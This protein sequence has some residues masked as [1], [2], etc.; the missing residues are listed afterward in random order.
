MA[1]NKGEQSSV[2]QGAPVVLGIEDLTRCTKKPKTHERE[3]CK[4][5]NMEVLEEVPPSQAVNQETTTAA[6]GTHNQWLPRSFAATLRQENQAL[7]QAQYY[8]GDEE[9]EKY[10]GVDELFNSQRLSKDTIP[11]TGPKLELSK[12]KYISLFK[13][14]R[15]A[16]II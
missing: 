3:T 9:E 11:S 15:G 2:V 5:S 6:S 8:M 4:A 12:E 10:P 1:D 14:W 16:L 7:D 13:P